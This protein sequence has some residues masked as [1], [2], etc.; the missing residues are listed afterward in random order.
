VIDL[1]PL[2]SL[3]LRCRKDVTF[4][5]LQ[6]GPA[7]IYDPEDIVF[8]KM[9]DPRQ[10]SMACRIISAGSIAFY[11]TAKRPSSA[12]ATTTTVRIWALFCI[13]ATQI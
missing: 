6:E 3:Y 5:V 13:P 9:Y 10:R 11:L 12:A 4:A 8:F 7:L 2:P 1:L